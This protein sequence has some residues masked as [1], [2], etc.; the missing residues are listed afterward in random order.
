MLKLRHPKANAKETIH[1]SDGKETE[2][3]WCKGNKQ[4]RPPPQAMYYL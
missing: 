1:F 4:M 2:K 3:K